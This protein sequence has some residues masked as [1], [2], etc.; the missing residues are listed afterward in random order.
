MNATTTEA[1]ATE[2]A[3]RVRALDR[4][5]AW[6]R[7]HLFNVQLPEQIPAAGLGLAA[8]GGRLSLA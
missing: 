2:S 3:R 5:F 1:V 7:A 6:T 4:F 8:V